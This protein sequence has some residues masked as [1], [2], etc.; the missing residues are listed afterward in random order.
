M[1]FNKLRTHYSDTI[2]I[3]LISS[4]P[5][6]ARKYFKGTQQVTDLA[7]WPIV[8]RLFISGVVNDLKG[9]LFLFILTY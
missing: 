7:G 3:N 8:L 9:E 2:F 1:Q 4:F 5:I 6:I